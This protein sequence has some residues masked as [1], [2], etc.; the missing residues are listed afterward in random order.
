MGRRPPLEKGRW[1]VGH[2]ARRVLSS[3]LKEGKISG[4]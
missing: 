1:D 4:F 2:H 3:Y